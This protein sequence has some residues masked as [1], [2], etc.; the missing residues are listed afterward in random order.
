M[1]YGH[2]ASGN[3]AASGSHAS[4]TVFATAEPTVTL[5]GVNAFIL[6]ML[7]LYNLAYM[8]NCKEVKV[9]C[10]LSMYKT[11]PEIL[12]AANKIIS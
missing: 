9:R 10:V 7:S 3:H 5:Q 8:S 11:G 4:S 2:A 6:K 12:H 1:D